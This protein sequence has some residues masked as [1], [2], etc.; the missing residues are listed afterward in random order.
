MVDADRI[1]TVG[2]SLGGGPLVWSA[3]HVERVK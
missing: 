1:G 2:T 3:A